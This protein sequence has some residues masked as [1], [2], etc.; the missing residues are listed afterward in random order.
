MS[1]H[2]WAG[3]AR[4]AWE[5]I[6]AGDGEA[7]CRL[8]TPEAVW[9][10]TGRGRHSGE[11]RGPEA[12]LDYLASI[13]EDVERFDSELEDILVGERLTA[14]LTRVSGKRQGREIESG[15]IVLLRI[16]GDKIAEMWSIPRDQLM[17]D[18]FW[19]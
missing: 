8:C 4:R 18:E 6:S 13:G 15:F 10:A 11:Y 12:I 17:I 1:I 9:H 14:I 16:Q 19:R 7:F 5:A 3:L 2:P